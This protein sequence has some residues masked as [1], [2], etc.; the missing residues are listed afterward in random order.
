MKTYNIKYSSGNYLSLENYVILPKKTGNSFVHRHPTLEISI[1]KSGNGV[2]GVENIFYDMQADDIFLF[3][4]IEEHGIYSVDTPSPM[5][6][7][8]IHFNPSF[9]YFSDSHFFDYRFLKIFF[10]R[11]EN[12][13]HRLDRFNPHTKEVARLLLEI[14]KE[15]IDEQ[16]S[17]EL[18][19]KVKLLDILVTL[20][21]YFGYTNSEENLNVTQ[22]ASIFAV[23]TVIN[24]IDINFNEDISLSGL[25]KR[26]NMNSSYLSSVFS[27]YNGISI[28][29]YLCK[30]RIVR[31]MEYLKSTDKNI[32][33]IASLCGFNNASNFNRIFKKTVNLSPSEYRKKG[34]VGIEI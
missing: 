16:D 20:I 29:D 21:R 31:A 5:T 15:F 27:K 33:E 30:T 11:T 14:E 12:F 17:Y 3:N 4:N 25:A 6:N 32:L 10:D 19:I 22:K 26:V 7:M 1:V 9:I 8:V 13:Q 23:R 28:W 24:Y 18:A 34:L 2:Y